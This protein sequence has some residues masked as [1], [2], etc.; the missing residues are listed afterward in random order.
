MK[1][2]LERQKKKMD[3]ELYNIISRVLKSVIFVAMGK[4]GF[5]EKEKHN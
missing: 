1:D 3:E 5:Q 4:K 2:K